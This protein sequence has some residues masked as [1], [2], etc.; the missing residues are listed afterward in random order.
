M[1]IV[2]PQ[3]VGPGWHPINYLAK[4][5]AELLGAELIILDG[6][7][8]PGK[9]QKLDALI[10]RRSTNSGAKAPCLLICPSPADLHALLLVPHWKKRF[11][12]IAA[13][14]ID[15]FWLNAVHRI[16]RWSRLFDHLFVTT[17]E[18]VPAWESLL[19]TPTTFLPWGSDVLR[20]GSG[21]TDRPL[22]LIRVGR[23][24]AEWDDDQ[25]ITSACEPI[26]IRFHGRP[27]FHG[28]AAANQSELMAMFAKSKF[29]LAFSNIAN[30][31]HYVHPT[32]E[33]LTARWVDSLASGAVVAGVA[34][35][36]PSINRLLWPG[37]TLDLGGTDRTDGLQII[38]QGVEI[39]RP[40]QAIVNHRNSL[41]RFDWRWRLAVIADKLQLPAPLLRAE[42]QTLRLAI[43]GITS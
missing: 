2:Y 23:Q 32:R 43:D 16:V 4:L 35:K 18:D 21:N 29:V 25:V 1:F 5:A 28:D 12:T 36:S 42:L 11:S 20:R 31:A 8:S 7:Q 39:W 38:R 15:S 22:D 9:L 27:T 33:Y 24:P 30:P 10:G 26:G 19:R 6:E 17:E 13:W 34:P 40:E 37:A 14:I 3:P 41:E